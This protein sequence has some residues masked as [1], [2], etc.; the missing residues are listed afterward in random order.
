[1][2]A[3]HQTNASKTIAQKIVRPGRFIWLTADECEIGQWRQPGNHIFILCWYRACSFAGSCVMKPLSLFRDFASNRSGQFA[4]MAAILSLPL[5]AAVGL[6]ID[7]SYAVQTRSRLRDANDAAALFAAQ[8]YKKTGILPD[9]ATILGFLTSNFNKSNSELDP[10]IKGISVKDFVLTIDANVSAPVFVMGIFGHDKVN[11]SAT[12][13]VTIA[14]NTNLEIALVL[15]TTKSMEAYTGNSSDELDPE[16]TYFNPPKGNVTR[17]EALKFSALGF[18]SAIFDNPG[19]SSLSRISIV[20]FAQYVNVG[21]SRRNEFWLDVPK[22]SD[23]TGETCYNTRNV[24]GT[25]N[26]REVL[27]TIDG[28]KVPQTQC[29]Y[30][31][32]PEYEVCYPTGANSWHGCVGSR[33]EPLNLQDSSP[34]SKF[35]GI[36]NV[37]CAAELQ[38]LSNDKDKVMSTINN[39]WTGNNTYIPEGVMWGLRTLSKQ[40]PFTDVKSSAAD[41]KIRKIMV[42]MTDGDNQAVANLPGAPTHRNISASD[43]D[44]SSAQSKTND[45]TLKACDE[46]KD[47]SVEVFTISFGTDISDTSKEIVESCAT[48]SDH[49]FDA[50]DA[51]TLKKAFEEI[52]YRVGATYLSN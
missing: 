6:S 39:L 47:A 17:I 27:V 12:S 43:S 9:N 46:A 37:W 22:D 41:L 33:L 23:A 28:A 29:D 25:S 21:T 31:Y 3:C 34:S 48:S 4:I 2:K 35:P 16:R 20:P 32:G 26:C 1:M 44:F 14:L 40:A 51:S 52:A 7:Y 18:A 13:S 15:D 49:Y 5:L 45:W 30:E 24:T 8:Q 50:K 36:M 19:L 11:I 10:V 38:T 42:L